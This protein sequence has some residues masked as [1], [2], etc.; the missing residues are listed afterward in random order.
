MEPTTVRTRPAATE[1]NTS[2]RSRRRLSDVAD[3]EDEEGILHRPR[4][5]APTRALYTAAVQKFLAEFS[6]P[7]SPPTATLDKYLN[8]KLVRLYLRGTEMNEARYIY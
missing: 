4:V 2:Q 7:P 3:D 6:L 1:A 5:K 8:T